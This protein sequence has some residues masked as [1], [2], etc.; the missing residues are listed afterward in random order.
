M[1][2]LPR[3]LIGLG[4]VLGGLG[5]AACDQGEPAQKTPK[6]AAPAEPKSVQMINETGRTNIILA[7]VADGKIVQKGELVCELDSEPIRED[8][9]RQQI[10]IP[11]AE[12]E[13][14]TSKLLREAAEL[15]IKEYTEGAYKN[16]VGA[17]RVAV[18]QT[19][20]AHEV[21]V[22][23]LERLKKNGKDS[24]INQNLVKRADREEKRTK[25]AMEQAERALS[26]FKDSEHPK[27]L[28]ELEAKA[29]EARAF[30]AEKKKAA[31]QEKAKKVL[32]ERQ[33]AACSMRAPIGG[34]L[35]YVQLTG[36]DDPMIEAGGDVNDR[37]PILRITAEED[38]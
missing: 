18:A 13:V 33:I 25:V 8:L 32:L 38:D 9:L 5:L 1:R 24:K 3:A 30:E 29:A 35:T 6:A 22:E 23:N 10:V 21:A 11:Q 31:D 2:S 12:Q 16:R 4:A 15:G 27:R 14:I 17:L 37:Q 34:E 28:K 20:A 19:E 26:T 7:I 36:K